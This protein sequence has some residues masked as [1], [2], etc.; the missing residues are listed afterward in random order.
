MQ[1]D[2]MIASDRE[3]CFSGEGACICQHK[4]LADT[5]NERVHTLN[6]SQPPS[7]LHY[8]TLPLFSAW[9]IALLPSESRGG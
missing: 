3:L 7:S 9:N 4:T 2:R 5:C 6:S 8:L 1:L